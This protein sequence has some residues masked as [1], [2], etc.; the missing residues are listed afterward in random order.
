MANG[1]KKVVQRHEKTS[2]QAEN[3]QNAVYC[4]QTYQKVAYFGKKLTNKELFAVFTNIKRTKRN[5]T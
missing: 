5:K 4:L 3:N 2:S 1:V